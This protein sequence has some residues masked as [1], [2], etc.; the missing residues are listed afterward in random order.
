MK[1]KKSG[2]CCIPSFHLSFYFIILL[3]LCLLS[4]ARATE[5]DDDD[6]N[7]SIESTNVIL[8]LFFG[9]ALGILVMQI[10][11]YYG[12][13]IPY[14]VVVF[15]LG[16]LFSLTDSTHGK[17]KPFFPLSRWCCSIRSDFLGVQEL[18]V[19]LSTNGLPLMLI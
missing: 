10:L 2:G 6:N 18:S 12:E 3:F 14:T 4:T 1:R 5:G 11:S 9:M 17:H 7:D 13:P 19:N 8:F 16:A 15:L